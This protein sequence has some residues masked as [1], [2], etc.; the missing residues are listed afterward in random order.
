MI[1]LHSEMFGD[2]YL[3]KLAYA[4]ANGFGATVVPEPHSATAV[5]GLA[6]CA[7]LARRR[8]QRV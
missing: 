8:R 5:G 3:E 6:A 4:E 1:A 2:E 7:A